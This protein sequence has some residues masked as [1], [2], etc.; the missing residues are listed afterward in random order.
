MKD[1]TAGKACLALGKNG[2]GLEQA[3]SGDGERRSG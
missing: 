2:A 3:A 1:K